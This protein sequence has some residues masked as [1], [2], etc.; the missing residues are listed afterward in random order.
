M[1]QDNIITLILLCAILFVV[2]Y[3]NKEEPTINKSE[4]DQQIKQLNELKDELSK[5]IIIVNKLEEDNKLQKPTTFISQPIINNPDNPI[6]PIDVV[7]VRDRN[8]FNNPLYPAIN[9][10]ERPIADSIINNGR[11]FNYPTRGSPDTYRP[12]AIVKNSNKEDNTMYYLMG[13]QKYQGSDLGN[14]YLASMN[15]NKNIKIPLDRN[16]TDPVFKYYDIPK[17]FT[18]KSG[19]F[20]GETFDTQELKPP[21]L[22]DMPYF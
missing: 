9:R 14:F 3:K 21:D 16:D 20:S 13:R 19:I 11:F 6:G 15:N 4:Y 18:I 17:Q 2:I 1:N 7:T 22:I 5:K 10:P 8:V 12:M